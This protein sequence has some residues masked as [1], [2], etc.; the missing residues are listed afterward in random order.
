MCRYKVDDR[1]RGAI[2]DYF[3]NEPP[4]QLKE[5]AP[6][7]GLRHHSAIDPNIPNVETSVP[8]SPATELAK[9]PALDSPEKPVRQ[10]GKK[11]R[12]GSKFV[13]D[14]ASVDGEEGEQ[15][16][17]EDDEKQ[18]TPRTKEFVVPDH[19]IEYAE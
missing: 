9:R 3:S 19:V 14:E 5:L 18:Q 13:D 11:P 1:T 6:E 12:K 16:D 4:S 2:L 17:E 15:D 7:S 8:G 10:K